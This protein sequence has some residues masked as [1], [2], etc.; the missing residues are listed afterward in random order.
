MTGCATLG[1]TTFGYRVRSD[2]RGDSPFGIRFDNWVTFG[3]EHAS[4]VGLTLISG[5]ASTF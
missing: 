2:G 4:M 5:C 1:M 3:I